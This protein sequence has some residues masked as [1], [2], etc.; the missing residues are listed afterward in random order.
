M[1]NEKRIKLLIEV[2]G[3]LVDYTSNKNIP[4]SVAPLE[5]DHFVYSMGITNQS[6]K[7]NLDIHSD[8]PTFSVDAPSPAKE[9][10]EK[11]LA[12]ILERYPI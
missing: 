12:S 5:N 1:Q 6:A 4:V 2:Y 10:I 9:E 3:R 7:V 8:T 11:L